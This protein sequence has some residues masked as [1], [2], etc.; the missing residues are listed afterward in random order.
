M[1]GFAK[2]CGKGLTGIVYEPIQGK[3]HARSTVPLRNVTHIIAGT[4][5]IFGYTGDGIVKSLDR[6]AHHKTMKK[7]LAAQQSESE[8][9]MQKGPV[10]LDE[11][12]VVRTFSQLR[13]AKGKMDEA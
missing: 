4:L 10:A 1:R 3:K 13:A 9:V 12:E 6:A 7:I 8:H 11:A 2:G 5:G